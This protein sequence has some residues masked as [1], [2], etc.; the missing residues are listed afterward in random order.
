MHLALKAGGYAVPP[1][2]Q[3]AFYSPG[4]SNIFPDIVG[5]LLSTRT[6]VPGRI[7]TLICRA[8]SESSFALLQASI[9]RSSPSVST[10][11]DSRTLEELKV[12]QLKDMCKEREIT[13]ISGYLKDELISELERWRD[14]NVPNSKIVIPDN[15][16][17]WDTKLDGLSAQRLRTECGTESIR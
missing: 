1:T 7:Q 16:A 5:K 11:Y 15:L 17:G 14:E 9:G 6:N 4:Q 13:G 2:Q 10:A 8:G 3:S 12:P